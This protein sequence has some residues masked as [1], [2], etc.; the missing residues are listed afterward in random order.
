MASWM[1]G[2]CDALRTSDRWTD[3][4]SIAT[5]VSGGAINAVCLAANVAVAPGS[6]YQDALRAEI[7]SGDIIYAIRCALEEALPNNV[8]SKISGRARVAIVKADGSSW[9]S[10]Q[11]LLVDQFRDKEDVIS[12]V[13]A[14]AHLPF[15]MN[16]KQTAL[17][18]GERYLDAAVF[19][20]GIIN[21]EGAVHV[22]ICPPEGY[23]PAGQSTAGLDHIRQG[24]L[25]AK[26]QA[27]SDVHPWLATPEEQRAHLPTDPLSHAFDILGVRTRKGAG[28]ERYRLGGEAFR[29]WAQSSPQ[30]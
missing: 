17:W 10:R 18:R 19:G 14:S 3:G 30:R 20:F 24:M 26:E 11:V 9:R 27:P 16:G 2:F 15:L 21:V 23:T 25:H 4:V 28:P 6:T 1:Y 29:T 8:A 13:C 5:G 22:S 7:R 12:A